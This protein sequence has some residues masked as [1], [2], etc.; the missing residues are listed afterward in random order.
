M[1]AVFAHPFWVWLVVGAALLALEVATGSG[2]LLWPAAA[3]GVVGLL[4]LAWPGLGWPAQAVAFA[5][6]TLVGT[7]AS[8]SALRRRLAALHAAPDLNDPAR[9]LLG[10]EG[11]AVGAFAGSGGRV[12]VDG[13]EWA[14]TLEPGAPAPAPGA[15]VVVTAVIGGARLKVRPR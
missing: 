2:Y 6:V 5:A 4:D 9:A 11:E 10:R 1:D 3:A 15:R 13:K 12:F 14:A 7:V 8:R